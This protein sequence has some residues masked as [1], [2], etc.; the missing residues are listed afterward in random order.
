MN[1]QFDLLYDAHEAVERFQKL[2]EKNRRIR[3]AKL[4]Q[5]KSRLSLKQQFGHQLIAFGRKLAKDTQ[6]VFE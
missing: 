1:K 2:A 3:E 5:L 6:P 4:G